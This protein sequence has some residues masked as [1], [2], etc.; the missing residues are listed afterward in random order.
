VE[1]KDILIVLQ[2][3]TGSTRLPEKV[4]KPFY[5][6]RSVFSIIAAK[7]Q[8]AMEHPLVLATTVNP[9]DDVLVQMA[10]TMGIP[11]FRGSEEDVLDR[12]IQ[13]AKSYNKKTIVRI[14]C[15]NPFLDMGLLKELVSAHMDSDADYTSFMDARQTPAI[16]THYGIF[17]EVVELETLK[18]AAGETDDPFY[19]E[20]VTNYIYGHPSS[21]KI[22][23]LPM[24]PSLSALEF[25]LTLDTQEDWNV[26][27]AL[28]AAC[29]KKYSS[30]GWRELVN[31]LKNDTH[32]LEIM[33]QQI[34]R[35]SK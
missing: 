28:Y 2:A 9:K 25:R 27:T 12:F 6:G 31:E 20:H 11:T 13:C 1:S 32:T 22:H 14:C 23:L 35:F 10:D 24:P 4:V 26:L 17:A 30:F 29:N 21:F 5:E 19:H 33:Q 34:K 18:R 3:R 16:K 8:E 7:L 15:D